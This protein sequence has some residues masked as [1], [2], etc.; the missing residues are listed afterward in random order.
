MGVDALAIGVIYIYI[1]ILLYEKMLK[2]DNAVGKNAMSVF[3][4]QTPRIA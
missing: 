1:Y 3:K 4:H 2:G